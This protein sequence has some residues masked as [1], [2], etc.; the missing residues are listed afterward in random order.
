[1]QM[2]IELWVSAYLNS[3]IS[4]FTRI[5]HSASKYQ[6]SNSSTEELIVSEVRLSSEPTCLC[7]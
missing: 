3:T 4:V 2:Y 1:M 6:I 5:F 7:W